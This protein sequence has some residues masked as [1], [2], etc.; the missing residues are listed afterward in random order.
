MDTSPPSRGI[1]FRTDELLG[2]VALD[3]FMGEV[4]PQRVAT[5]R[6]NLKALL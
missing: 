3:D 5:Q 2:D 6:F 1:P 4:S